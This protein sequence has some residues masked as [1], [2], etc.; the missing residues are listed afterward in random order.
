M[1]TS[2]PAE[3]M[4]EAKQRPMVFLKLSSDDV[5]FG[6]VEIELFSDLVPRAAENFRCLCTGEKGKGVFDKELH[7]KGSRIHRIIRGFLLQGG[8]FIYGNGMGNESIYGETFEDEDLSHSFTHERGAVSMANAGP[9]T[10][11]SQFF[12][13]SANAPSLDGS[14]V[15]VGRVVDGMDVLKRVHQVDCNQEDEP[16]VSVFISDCGEYS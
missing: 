14:Y 7:Y 2:K 12:I 5:E 4:K 8:D 6:T 16:L 1:K 11:G 9:D 3:L 15:V 10:N 13:T